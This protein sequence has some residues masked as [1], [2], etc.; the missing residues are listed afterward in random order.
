MIRLL[1]KIGSFFLFITPLGLTCFAS[2]IAE[3]AG[4]KI[5]VALF[6]VVVGRLLLR[7]L[8]SVRGVIPVLMCAL[9]VSMLL[10]WCTVAR[11]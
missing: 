1:F 9:C 5:A 3:A 7:R 10:L 6:G 2:K 4:P 11:R 8:L